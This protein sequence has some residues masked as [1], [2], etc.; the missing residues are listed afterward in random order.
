MAWC[1]FC[2]R[3]PLPYI[4]VALLKR[5]LKPAAASINQ[6]TL[7]DAHYSTASIHLQLHRW[8]NHRRYV[9]IREMERKDKSFVCRR[10]FKVTGCSYCNF[11]TNRDE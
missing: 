9:F 3:R 1:H 7:L 2:R 4:I 5:S 8:S 6:W 11:V 10:L